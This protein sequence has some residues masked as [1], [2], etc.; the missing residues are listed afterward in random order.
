MTTGSMLSEVRTG[1]IYIK[2]LKVGYQEHTYDDPI[3][4]LRF[5]TSIAAL[6]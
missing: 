5:Y 6:L 3:I 1:I 2:Q 4:S